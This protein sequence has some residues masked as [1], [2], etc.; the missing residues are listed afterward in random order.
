[1]S[2]LIIRPKQPPTCGSCHFMVPNPQD[3]NMIV[4]KGVPPTP[5][6]TGAQ[7]TVAGIQFQI[8]HLYA[9]LPRASRACSLW[10]EKTPD[11]AGQN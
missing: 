11:F 3:L 2:D 1:M 8:E 5:C 9:Q 10:R 6:I 4:C 7:Q